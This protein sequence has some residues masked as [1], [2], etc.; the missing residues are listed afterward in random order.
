MDKFN[1]QNKQYDFPYHYI[2]F[3][4]KH[5]FS[6][7][8]EL[9]WGGEY[10]AYLKF[11]ILELIKDGVNEILDVG[12][13][14][15]RFISEISSYGFERLKGIDISKKAIDFAKAFNPS[16]DFQVADITQMYEK[17]KAIT[18][19][20]CLEHIPDSMLSR[21][22][23]GLES[24]L[25]E[26]GRLYIT[27]PSASMPIIA[28]HYR[29]YTLQILQKELKEAN[30]HLMIEKVE[31]IVPQETYVDKIVSKLLHNRFWEF[32]IY[33]AFVWKRLWKNNLTTS[34]PKCKHMYVV[35]K[36]K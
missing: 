33:N 13:G 5:A 31:Y 16:L 35:L 29:H 2:P 23:I 11:V 7:S 19:I 4:T 22:I 21:F 14:D 27:V 18:C 20:E 9:N 1:I 6:R 26:G 30:S 15:G 32:K 8:R 25:A 34:E 10:L 3:Y 12:C 28:K 36:K 24:N 17:W